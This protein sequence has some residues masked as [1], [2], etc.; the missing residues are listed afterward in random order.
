MH[1]L[2]CK[3]QGFA[4]LADSSVYLKI[5]WGQKLIY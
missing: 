4:Y 3:L 2:K 1:G 5:W